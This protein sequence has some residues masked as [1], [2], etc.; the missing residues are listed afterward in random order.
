MKLDC[1]NQV[2]CKVIN[3]LEMVIFSRFHI[4]FIHQSTYIYLLTT[5]SNFFHFSFY[6]QHSDP[7]FLSLQENPVSC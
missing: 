5:L 6:Q 4:I 7:L 3:K 1:K 2:Y